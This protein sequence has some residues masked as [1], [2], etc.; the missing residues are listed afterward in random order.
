MTVVVAVVRDAPSGLVVL[1]TVLLAGAAARVVGGDRR[2]EGLAVRSVWVDVLV[3]TT[4]ALGIGLLALS[5][6]V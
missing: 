5:P 3:L 1:T 6:N 4:L 2:P